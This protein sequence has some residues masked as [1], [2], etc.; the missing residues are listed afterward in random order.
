MCLNVRITKAVAKARS[1]AS[2][3]YKRG[4]D[5]DQAVLSTVRHHTVGLAA[6]GDARVT[7]KL[8]IFL[9]QILQKMR[10]MALPRSQ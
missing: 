7:G 10:Q 5:E 3:T 9:L 6:T 4:D 1:I 8:I 2:G